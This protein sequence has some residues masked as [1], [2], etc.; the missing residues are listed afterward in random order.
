[1]N[2]EIIPIFPVPVHISKYEKDLTKEQDFI[3]NISY[4]PN[5]SNGNFKS[6]NNY[7]IKSLFKTF[8]SFFFLSNKI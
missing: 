6:V 2:E 1:M 3:K 5:G 8:S 7:N 4:V